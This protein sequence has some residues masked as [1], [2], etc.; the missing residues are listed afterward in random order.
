LNRP[1]T[2]L[3]IG[4][5]RRRKPEFFECRWLRHPE[6]LGIQRF[7]MFAWVAKFREDD[8]DA[9]RGKPVPGHKRDT[10]EGLVKSASPS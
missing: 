9:L 7:T 8:V 4:R 3:P 6:P 2:C 1:I 5:L 10:C